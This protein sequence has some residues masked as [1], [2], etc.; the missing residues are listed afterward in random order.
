ML[1]DKRLKHFLDNNQNQ[2]ENMN[3]KAFATKV[4]RNRLFLAIVLAGLTLTANLIQP[5]AA[6]A[7]ICGGS[8]Q[9]TCQGYDPQSAGCNTDAMT[10]TFTYIVPGGAGDAPISIQEVRHSAACNGR[11]ARSKN[12]LTYNRYFRVELRN[13]TPIVI[14]GVNGVAGNQGVVYTPVSVFNTYC[15]SNFTRNT[16]DPAYL[17]GYT[18]QTACVNP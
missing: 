9:P 15:R 3:E 8:G 6:Y 5:N 13:S 18:A 14:F 1:L 16:T 4:I 12:L 17:G 2:G 7:A 11:W 10:R